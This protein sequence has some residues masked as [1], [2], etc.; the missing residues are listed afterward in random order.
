MTI[1]KVAY[2]YAQSLL[3][4]GKEQNKLEQVYSDMTYLADVC[5]ESKDFIN[6]LNSP[7]VDSAK[8]MDVFNAL[9]ASKMDETSIGFMKLIVKNGREALLAEI[10]VGFVKLYK[11]D[12][13]ILEVTVTSAT[14]LD[15]G[16]RDTIIAKI[17]GKFDGTIEMTEEVDPELIGGFVVRIDDQQ[18]DASI[19]SQLA[20]LKNVLLN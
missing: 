4:L 18:I 16:T 13:N 15:N 5:N 20:N 11:K 9:F 6:L 10:A 12:K 3:D 8:K 14:T 19:A 17:K 2:R 1:S 7:I